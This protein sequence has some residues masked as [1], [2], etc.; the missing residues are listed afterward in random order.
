[1]PRLLPRV[2]VAPPLGKLGDAAPSLTSDMG[3]D[4]RG[5]QQLSF[6]LI[7]NTERLLVSNTTSLLSCAEAAQEGSVAVSLCGREGRLQSSLLQQDP[8][9]RFQAHLSAL[10]GRIQAAVLKL[11]QGKF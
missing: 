2:Q 4:Q 11:P 1:M 8:G 7:I 9:P 3:G 10:Y 5:L 6:V